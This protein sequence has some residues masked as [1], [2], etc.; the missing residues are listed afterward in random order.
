M[1]F[2]LICSLIYLNHFDCFLTVENRLWGFKTAPSRQW[3]RNA[4]SNN[5]YPETTSNRKKKLWKV[6]W[7]LKI[8]K[9]KWFG[10]KN[11]TNQIAWFGTRD[12]N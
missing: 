4:F 12:Q 1:F 6:I 5:L 9:L 7:Y 10:Y 8:L 2:E 11:S 3:T